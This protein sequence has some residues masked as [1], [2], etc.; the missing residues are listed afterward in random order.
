MVSIFFS[1]RP[2]L[3][4]ISTIS[5]NILLV[6]NVLNLIFYYQ[7]NGRPKFN[8]TEFLPGIKFSFNA[9]PLGLIFALMASVLW[10]AT[11]IYSSSY[12]RKNPL[13]KRFY[14][15]IAASMV[16]TFGVA[17]S[18][19]LL[20]LFVCYELLTFATFPL[21][22]ISGD[23]ASK[24]AGIKYMKYLFG[25]SLLFFFPALVITYYL[26]GNANFQG[27]GIIVNNTT[28]PYLLTI[29]F[30]FYMLGVAKAAI[31]PLHGWLPSAMV[32]PIPVSSLLHAVAVVKAGVF[33]IIK[34]FVYVFG[35]NNLNKIPY[36]NLIILLPILSVI[37]SSIYAI[38]QDNLKKRLAYS[39]IS[40]LSYSIMIA[41]LAT[42]KAIIASII[43]MVAHAVAKITL[44]FC[45]GI[46]YKLTGK[47]NLSEVGGLA[48]VMP[49][50]AWCIA[51]CCL[52]LIGFP[53]LAG[54]ISKYYMLSAATEFLNIT[55]ICTIIIST[56]FSA[57]YLVPIIS[58]MF[59]G[60]VK[61]EDIV[62][63]EKNMMKYA[64]VITTT[65]TIFMFIFL[66]D[67]V[68]LLEK[69]SF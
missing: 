2:K 3:R 24:E 39:T 25:S 31:I 62:Y 54:F 68:K 40:Q 12:M 41:T 44:F 64:I 32:A 29:L 10:L 7:H 50:T 30:I 27:G 37:L 46:I 65:I 56:L 45:V 35:I 49:V 19:N 16:L 13:Q 42:P 8:I 36:Y 5:L 26:A 60:E 53:P 9:E 66:K 58:S 1:Y 57:M 20:T 15:F 63:K 47:T 22:R 34:I 14:I 4:I 38:F 11:T 23:A 59:L 51:I 61:H 52:S 28:N 69:V 33:T 18:A 55:I 21:V 48:K 67:T 6:I 43:Q 17:F